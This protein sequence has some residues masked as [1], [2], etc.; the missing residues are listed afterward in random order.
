[1]VATSNAKAELTA[2]Y[3]HSFDSGSSLIFWEGQ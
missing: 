1:M 2:G 3:G